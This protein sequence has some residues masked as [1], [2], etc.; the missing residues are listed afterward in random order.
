MYKRADNI[1]VHH[2]LGP[3]SK[4]TMSPFAQDVQ[5]NQAVHKYQQMYLAALALLHIL[6]KLE[7]TGCFGARRGKG[8]FYS[9]G[10]DQNRFWVYA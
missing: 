6:L 1:K 10:E 3:W 5:D 4:A 9:S 7:E 8:T 2:F